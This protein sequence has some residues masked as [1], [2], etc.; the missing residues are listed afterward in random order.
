[1]SP[2]DPMPPIDL[3]LDVTDAVP[4]PVSGGKQMHVAA[5]LFARSDGNFPN[6]RPV[7][8]CLAGGTYDRRYYHVHIPGHPG[9]S[10]AEYLADRGAIVLVLDHLGIGDSSRPAVQS[11]LTRDV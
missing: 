2:K 7:I 5:W 4:Q 9:Y 11:L 8:A 10:M 3:K 6:P 1:M